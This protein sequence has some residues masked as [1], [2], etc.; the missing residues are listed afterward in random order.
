[1]D[2]D[3]QRET[4]GEDETATGGRK[5]VQ[6]SQGGKSGAAGIPQYAAMAL[7][8]GKECQGL[9]VLILHLQAIPKDSYLTLIRVESL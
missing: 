4:E 6:I 9:A 5:Y 2:P 3:S 1:M 7:L 8:M